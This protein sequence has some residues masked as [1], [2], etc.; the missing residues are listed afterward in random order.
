MS[1]RHVY[2]SA[3]ISREAFTAIAYGATM[4]DRDLTYHIHAHTYNVYGDTPCNDQCALIDR[5]VIFT[6]G[7]WGV[8]LLDAANE[9]SDR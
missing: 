3:G 4:I 2:I 8:T 6:G 1:E 5:G 9:P 7:V